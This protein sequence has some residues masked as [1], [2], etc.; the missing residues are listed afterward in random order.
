MHIRPPGFVLYRVCFYSSPGIRPVSCV[1]LFV[2]RD[3]SCIVCVFIRPPGFVLYRVCFYSSPGIRPVSCVF[4]FVPRDS[5][6]IVCVFIR[7]PGFV[8]YR[9]CFYSSPGIR[10]VSCVFLF[11]PRDSSCIV[12]VLSST[13]IGKHVMG[14]YDDP[15]G[16]VRR[17][18]PPPRA[19]TQAK[20]TTFGRFYL[21]PI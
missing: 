14:S 10:P 3:S 17:G 2:P 13:T 16:I 21:V 11:V 19:H 18:M 20:H 1:F 9:V 6:C 7:P 5:S 12:C 15:M 4:L 8:L